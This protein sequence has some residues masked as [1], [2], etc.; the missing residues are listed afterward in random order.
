MCCLHLA[1]E[2]GTDAGS[3]CAESKATSLR[4]AL[5]FA[6]PEKEWHRSLLRKERDSEALNAAPGSGIQ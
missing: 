4:A 3:D 6:S 5:M 1:Q 2:N